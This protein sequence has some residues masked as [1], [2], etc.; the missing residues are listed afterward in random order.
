MQK[1]AEENT[2]KQ[3]AA[4]CNLQCKVN[5]GEAVDAVLK[6]ANGIQLET[7]SVLNQQLKE[8][9]EAHTV[10]THDLQDTSMLN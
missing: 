3:K 1:S 10:H 5:K 4:I 8:E 6:E 9:K 7:N 2:E